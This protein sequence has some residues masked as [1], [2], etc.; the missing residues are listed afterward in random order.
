MDDI[1]NEQRALRAGLPYFHG[2][3]NEYIARIIRGLFWA[4]KAER[5]NNNGWGAKFAVMKRLI[6]DLIGDYKRSHEINRLAE[7]KDWFKRYEGD[8]IPVEDWANTVNGWG[9]TPME[10]L[11]ALM[12]EEELR[13]K[14]NNLKTRYDALK[15]FVPDDVEKFVLD[16]AGVDVDA[17]RVNNLNRIV[18]EFNDVYRRRNENAFNA[19]MDWLDDDFADYFGTRFITDD[20]DRIPGIED[21]N[22]ENTRKSVNNYPYG[23]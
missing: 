22:Y 12:K 4:D 23:F 9:H 6:L 10:T 11:D 16:R 2:K 7:G 3:D 19:S 8:F 17:V 14:L 5:S 1:L 20:V 21:F 13:S 18:D 15:S